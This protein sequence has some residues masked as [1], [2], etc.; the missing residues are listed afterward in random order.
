MSRVTRRWRRG[1]SDCT[2]PIPRSR[3]KI[4]YAPTANMKKM[5]ISTSNAVRVTETARWTMLPADGSL[6]SRFWR[7]RRISRLIPVDL[8]RLVTELRR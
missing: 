1:T 7:P 8:R 5:P 6:L 3:S 4:Q 2:S